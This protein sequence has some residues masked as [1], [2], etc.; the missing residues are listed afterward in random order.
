MNYFKNTENDIVTSI[1]TLFNCNQF[2]KSHS[3][4]D[5]PFYT[6]FV[7]ESQLFADFIY[8]RMIP[9]NKQEIIDILLVNDIL[10]KIKKKNRLFG[11]I[12][13]NFPVVINIKEIIDILS[14]SQEN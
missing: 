3:S 6:K 8:K 13:Q 5:I 4:S 9:K 14:Q 12:K 2:I 11:K 7:N 1:E 10:I